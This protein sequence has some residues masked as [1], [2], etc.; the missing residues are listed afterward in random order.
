[1]LDAH[2]KPEGLHGITFKEP[3]Q[4]SLLKGQPCGENGK[5]IT[6]TSMDAGRLYVGEEPFDENPPTP[7]GN[8]YFGWI[9]LTKKD[10]DNAVWINLSNVDMV[11]LPL[12]IEATESTS[13]NTFSLGYKES[14][15][16]LVQKLQ[17][18]NPKAVVSPSAGKSKILA[19]QHAP[20]G[21]PPE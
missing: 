21:T 1:M 6:F 9:E 3:T 16:D 18:L 11:G 13:K 8:S 10:T 12:A 17:K 15:N 5:T 4:F 19:P 7:K 14:I 20:M 2:S